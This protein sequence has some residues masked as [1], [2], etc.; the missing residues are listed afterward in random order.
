MKRQTKILTICLISALGLWIVALLS[1]VG[2]TLYLDTRMPAFPRSG[3]VHIYE[4]EPMDSV[5]MDFQ[6]VLEPLHPRS[7]R[8][9]IKRELDG[10][11]FH[12][13]SYTFKPTNSARYV[14]RAITRGWQSPVTMTISGQ[15]RTKEVL[16]GRIA[17]N[18]KIDSAVVLA[19]L[20]DSIL[21]AQY[22][23]T[24]S[25]VFEMILPD[26]YECYWN[27][28]VA[29]ILNKFKKEYDIYWTKERRNKAAAQGLTP[30]QVSALASIVCEESN[31]P[32]EYPKIASVYLTRL[33]KGMKLQA[34]PTVRYI[35]GYK[36]GRV[37]YSHLANPSPYNTYY[38]AGLP[39]T[40]ICLPGK[41]H[42]EAVL[43]P[44]KHNYLYFCA[45]SEL[46]GRNVFSES[47]DEHLGKARDY[48]AAVDDWKARKAAEKEAALQASAAGD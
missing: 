9:C 44:D 34:C 3:T 4:G 29:K 13:G 33:H 10:H 40:P 31:C 45:D 16:A 7:L 46:N 6:R 43:N 30:Q 41:E 35:Y 42:I 17:A 21:L 27:W 23:T 15:I 11:N 1:A 47:Y 20:N 26:S 24:P 37:L 32:D 5:L 48:H 25:H 36:I 2:A 12:E 28:G 8:R 22:G 39:P 18:M 19:A 38:H 14:A